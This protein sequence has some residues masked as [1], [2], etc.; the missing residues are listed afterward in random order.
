MDLYCKLGNELRA[1]FKDLF[2]PARRGTCKAQMDD[3]L[4]MAAQIGGPLA[5]EAELLYMDVLRFL[6]HPEDKETVAILQEHALKLE[7]ETREL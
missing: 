1:M 6:Q 5:M 2:N 3:I 7:Q 4:S